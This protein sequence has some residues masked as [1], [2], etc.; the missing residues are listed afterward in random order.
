MRPITEYEDVDRQKFEREIVPKGEPAVIRGLVA[1][2]TIVQA[3]VEGDVA[4][5]AF[6]RKAS[7]EEPFQTWFGTPEIEGR[8]GYSEDFSSFNHERKLATV[9]QLLDLLLRQKRNERPYSMYAG[10]IP[11]RRHVDCCQR[12]RCPCSTLTRR[13]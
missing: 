1:N 12:S 11:I 6:L 7:T 10:G 13:H 4:M 2:W 5:A 9:E 3:A 8:F